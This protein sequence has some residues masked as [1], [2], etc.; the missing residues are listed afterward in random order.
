MLNTRHS[1]H[2]GSI[3]IENTDEASKTVILKERKDTCIGGTYEH[4]V[5]SEYILRMF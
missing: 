1:E 2:D 5:Y 3:H 4:F